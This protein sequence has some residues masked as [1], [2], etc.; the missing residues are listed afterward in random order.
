MVRVALTGGIA[1]GK[2]YVAN[3]MRERGIP[4]V[5]ADEL[6][7]RVLASGTESAAEVVKRF[8]R[9]VSTPE[10]DIDRRR[11][12]AIVFADPAARADLEA[13]IHPQVYSAID[14]WFS[15][16]ESGDPQSAFAVADVPLLFETRREG[17]FDRVVV[18]FCPSA[19]QIERVQAR[20]GLT[21]EQA[22]QRLGAQWPIE[23]K[24]RLADYVIRTD[25]TF[26]ETDSQLDRVVRALRQ[27]A[28]DRS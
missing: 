10:G 12:G 1:S 18:A 24:A 15:D 4:V 27:D 5:D 25:G 2:S 23:E 21:A 17:A 7:H 16:L 20:D 8:G 11:L 26:N 9:T 14:R 6:S 22:R 19:V 28:R 3:R 13:I